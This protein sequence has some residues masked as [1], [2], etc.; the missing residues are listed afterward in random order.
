[1]LILQMLNNLRYQITFDTFDNCM[2]NL[3]IKLKNKF[4]KELKTQFNKVA[5]FSNFYGNLS[6]I[7]LNT[8]KT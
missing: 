2:D 6:N 8:N 7:Y 5:Q 3:D 4:K 1:M